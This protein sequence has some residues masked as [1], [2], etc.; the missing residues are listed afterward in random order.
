MSESAVYGA[1]L[2]AVMEWE[3]KVKEKAARGREILFGKDNPMTAE[4]ACAAE[5][6][7]RRR[8]PSGRWTRRNGAPG[9]SHAAP[10]KRRR[11]S[12]FR[13]CGRKAK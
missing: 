10:G 1:F 3:D 13:A 9:L 2:C 7:S 8:A 12:G 5:K 11:R 6:A 4:L